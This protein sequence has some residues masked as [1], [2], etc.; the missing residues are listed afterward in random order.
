M[1]MIYKG[2]DK[3][4]SSIEEAVSQL[5]LDLPLSRGQGTSQPPPHHPGDSSFLLVWAGTGAVPVMWWFKDGSASL[6]PEGV[7]W[8]AAVLHS[9]TGVWNKIHILWQ[10]KKNLNKKIFSALWHPLPPHCGLCM[11]IMHHQTSPNGRNTCS[12]IN[13]NILLASTRQLLKR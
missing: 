4:G 6:R 13:S 5:L 7:K 1:E 10:D 8:K 11:C 9:T 3:A 12:T 2:K